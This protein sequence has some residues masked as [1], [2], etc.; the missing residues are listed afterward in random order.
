MITAPVVVELSQRHLVI[1]VRELDWLISVI[2]DLVPD[3]SGDPTVLVPSVPLSFT[4]P[5]ILVIVALKELIS[6]VVLVT[7]LILR[8][9]IRRCRFELSTADKAIV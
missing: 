3:R 1:I 4:D 7:E 6:E 5:S 9:E 2:L 8:E